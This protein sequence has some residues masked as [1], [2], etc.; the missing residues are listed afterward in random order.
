MSQYEFKMKSIEILVGTVEAG[1]LE[2][3]IE[4]AKNGK[5]VGDFRVIDSRDGEVFDFKEV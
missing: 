3:A 4:K 1:S 2:E 5:T